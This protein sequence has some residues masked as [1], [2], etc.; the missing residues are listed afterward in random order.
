[1]TPEGLLLPMRL[2]HRTLGRL[3]GAQRPTVTLA[4]G[5]LVT[6]GAIGTPQPGGGWVLR[7]GP[8]GERRPAWGLATGA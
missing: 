8:D 4:V 5:Q 1:M 3:I 6:A 7:T 2:T